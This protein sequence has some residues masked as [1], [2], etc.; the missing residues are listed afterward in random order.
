MVLDWE[1]ARNNRIASDQTAA[2]AR[3]EEKIAKTLQSAQNLEELKKEVT[4][5]L[6]EARAES[7][8]TTV[9]IR[10]G[11]RNLSTRRPLQK[12]AKD[13]FEVNPADINLLRK[14]TGL[15]LDAM[16]ETH[17]TF[18]A[19]GNGGGKVPPRGPKAAVGDLDDSDPS[20]EPST[21]TRQPSLMPWKKPPVSE[22][23]EEAMAGF[24]KILTATFQQL[25]KA[26]EDTGKR[27]PIKAPETFD[28][29]FTKFRRWWE[30][31]NEYFAI[32]QKR[33]PN[34]ETKIYSLGTFLR[35]QAADWYTET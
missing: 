9:D 34:D 3:M 30:S 8:S 2:L 28:G 25:K 27:L 20:S 10:K 29:S 35:D 11:L 33:V 4:K 6:Q 24:P 5:N 14:E 13:Y 26:D 31:I 12:T 23:E 19:G 32:H 21:P 15:D 17:E 16:L 1:R 7:V 18:L 22:N